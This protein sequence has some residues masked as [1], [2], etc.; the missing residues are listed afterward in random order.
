MRV[1]AVRM[2]R[3]YTLTT[4]STRECLRARERERERRRETG[5]VNRFTFLMLWILFPAH[6]EFNLSQ[7]VGS[8]FSLT[9]PPFSTL[10]GIRFNWSTEELKCVSRLI[11]VCLCKSIRVYDCVCVCFFC[12]HRCRLPFPLE[13]EI[14]NEIYLFVALNHLLC[15]YFRYVFVVI[16]SF[17]PSNSIQCYFLHLFISLSLLLCMTLIFC[18]P[19]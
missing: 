17:P 5:E 15:L 8:S 9:L 10:D 2:C 19:F 6:K 12:Y 1:C 16:L 4:T 11:C 7:F 14:F 3:L 18:L 13:N